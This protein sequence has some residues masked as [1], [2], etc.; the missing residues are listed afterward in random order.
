MKYFLNLVCVLLMPLM[1]WSGFAQEED[2]LT[3]ENQENL[4]VND[5]IKDSIP[6]PKRNTVRIKVDGIAAVVGDYLILDSDIQKGMM[7]AR[8]QQMPDSEINTCG[9][10]E[11][12]IENKYFVHHAVQDSIEVS[13]ERIMMFASEQMETFERE[14]GG[15]NEVLKIF[16]KS[17]E[18]EL[19]KELEKFHYDRE[20]AEAMKNDIIGDLEVTPE[21]TR[22]FFESIP[23]DELPLFGDEIEIAQIVIEPKVGE[24]E[25]QA[26]I[27]RLNEMRENILS[28]GNLDDIIIAF[29]TQAT[30]YTEDLGSKNTGG[31][32]TLTRKDPFVKEFKDAAFSQKE[33]EISKPFKTDFGY[34]IL[35]VEKIRGQQIDVRHILLYPEVTQKAIDEAKEAAEKLRRKLLTGDIDFA[36][37]A[38]TFSDEKETRQ[39]GGQLINPATGD[40]RFELSKIDPELYGRVYSLEEDELSNVFLDEDRTGKKQFK[41]LKVTKRINEHVADFTIDYPKIKDLAL[42]RKQ[43]REIKKWRKIKAK[44]TYIKINPDYEHC[45]F[46]KEWVRDSS[47]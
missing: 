20:M 33:G 13:E 21:E 7:D 22:Q 19:R 39:N 17:N 27:D 18:D 31:K 10:L 46:I 5:S 40:K 44:D 14:A 15:M 4:S 30:F 34:H 28:R 11:R 16:G 45:D 23:K 47:M 35:L 8:Q 26:V 25:N 9:I 32:Y 41:I 37:A 6:E 12:L 36:D 2:L 43:I 38:K 1:S 3:L 24:K 42:R 29:T